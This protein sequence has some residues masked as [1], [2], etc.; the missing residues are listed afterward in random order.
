MAKVS[1]RKTYRKPDVAGAALAPPP[2]KNRDPEYRAF[3]GVVPSSGKQGS[4][5][6]PACTFGKAQ[7]LAQSVKVKLFFAGPDAAAEMTSKVGRNFEPGAYLRV[8]GPKTN[9][10]LMF[11]SAPNVKVGMK[12][13]AAV[14]K[15]IDSEGETPATC[16]MS[17]SKLSGLRRKTKKT[18]RK[19]PSGRRRSR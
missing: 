3:D 7:R 5:F 10:E 9:D 13:A 4:S 16:V 11:V 12:Q 18:T 1:S 2:S 17:A 6:I 19:A 8:C 14:E 15:C